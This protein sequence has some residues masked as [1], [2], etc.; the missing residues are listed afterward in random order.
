MNQLEPNRIAELFVRSQSIEVAKKLRTVLSEDLD[1]RVMQMPGPVVHH[2]HNVALFDA[3]LGINCLFHTKGSA[4]AGL[5]EY[6]G[7]AETL[8]PK[9]L[10]I[11]D[12]LKDFKPASEQGE[13][14]NP[15]SE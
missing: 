12:S 7:H 6:L 15:A 3:L 9:F 1:E 14:N 8:M 4:E 5:R 11:V 2:V 13:D 10:D